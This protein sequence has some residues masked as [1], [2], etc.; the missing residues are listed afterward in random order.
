MADVYGPAQEILILISL[1]SSNDSG[2]STHLRTHQSLCCSH[3]QSMDVIGAQKKRLNEAVLLS[4]H[5]L[6]FSR[7]IRDIIFNHTVLSGGQHSVKFL[8]PCFL[9]CSK[10]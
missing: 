5:N 6:G 8:F 10:G 1:F 9:E 7:A 4:T 2:M 3:M